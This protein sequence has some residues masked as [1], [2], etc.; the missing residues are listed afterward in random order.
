M[1]WEAADSIRT[2]SG[3]AWVGEIVIACI[4]GAPR[5]A[6][7]KAVRE[8]TDANAMIVAI[9]QVMPRQAGAEHNV[10]ASQLMAASA[11]VDRYEKPE[12]A[13]A[14]IAKLLAQLANANLPKCH[15]CG[16]PSTQS[17]PYFLEMDNTK[18]PCCADCAPSCLA[19]AEGARRL[20]Q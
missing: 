6:T 12:S 20:E 13:N 8:S 15:Q 2:S 9:V 4:A 17:C 16:G 7:L 18:R 14:H 19:C 1:T 3:V 5:V 11:V 10:F